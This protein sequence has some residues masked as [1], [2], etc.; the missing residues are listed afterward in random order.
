[1]STVATAKRRVHPDA[2]AVFNL[3]YWADLDWAAPLAQVACPVLL[4]HTDPESG[5][6]LSAADAVTF[7]RH[8]PQAE[9][10]YIPGATHS[11]RRDCLGAYLAA[12]ERLVR[13]VAA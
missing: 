2:F 3:E 5:G 8:V 4:I 10:A 11:I 6:V 9:V 7:Q 13:S 1:M 12:V